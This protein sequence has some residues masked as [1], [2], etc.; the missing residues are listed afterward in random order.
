MFEADNQLLIEEYMA[1]TIKEKSFE[2]EARLWKNYKT[3]YKPIVKFAFD[4]KI[5]FVATNVPRRYASLVNKQGFEA[6]DSLSTEAKQYF[7]PLPV[8]FDPE[9]PGYKGMVEMMRSIDSTHTTFNIAKAQ[10]LKD[11]T[12]AYFILQNLKPGQTFLHFNGSYHS[13]NF[14][15]VVWYIR[16]ANPDLKILTIASTELDDL[17]T[18]GSES[19]GIADFVLCVPSSMTKTMTGQ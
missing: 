15:G 9:L 14:E 18:L 19:N 12:M 16:Q 17:D 3:D 6:L 8:A 1:G 2:E 4:H 11:A 7:A 10:A 5:P 13:E